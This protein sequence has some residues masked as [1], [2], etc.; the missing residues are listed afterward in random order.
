MNPED[1]IRFAEAFT[2]FGEAAELMV[3]PPDAAVIRGKVRRRRVA[4]VAV[5]GVAALALIAPA[6]WMLQ[7]AATAEERDTPEVADDTNTTVVEEEQ[8]TEAEEAA[9][10]EDAE[11][12]TEVESYDD[13]DLPTVEDLVGTTIDGLSSFMPGNDMVDQ[14]CPVDGAVLED[15]TTGG[16]MDGG[17]RIGLLEVV[18]VQMSPDGGRELPVLLLGCRFGEA[19][20]Y[21]VVL[22]DQSEGDGHWYFWEQLAASKMNA[23]SPY[24][25]APGPDYGVLIGI[26]ERYACCGT[27]P[28]SLE[29][30]VELASLDVSE[31]VL[32]RVEEGPLPDLAVT[33]EATE[34]D[35]AGVW[36]VEAAVRNDGDEASGDYH[37]IVCADPN[38]IAA[39]FEVVDCGIDAPAIEDMNGLAPGEEYTASWEVTV[40]PS[41][42][43]IDGA[44][45][46]LEIAPNTFNAEG[47]ARDRTL[48]DNTATVE[49]TE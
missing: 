10:S 6:S 18:H 20:A 22:L 28:D 48:A 21:Q 16:Y 24:D 4:R 47:I 31:P 40:A 5:A 44:Y 46:W 12:E 34:T 3:E 35:E 39:D 9:P 38:E 1:E 49:F 42:E 25:I 32:E 7:Q 17:G 8:P 29:Y 14:A 15:G 13:D 19:A 41:S 36:T 23:D 26:A 33:V 27:D 43:W 30:R 2:E 45:L 37:L 11:T